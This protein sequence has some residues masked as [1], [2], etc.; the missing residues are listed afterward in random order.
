MC[1]ITGILN[2]RQTEPISRRAI[3][4]MIASLHHRGPDEAGIY[5]DD[6]IGLG[7]ARLSIIDL[8]GGAQPI[9]NEDESLWIVYNGEVFNYPELREG[10]VERG[11]S[12][13]TSSDTEVIL[14]LFEELG[15]A[16]LEQ[17][18]GQWA[19]AIWNAKTGELFLAR[20]RVGIRPLHYAKVGDRLIFGSEIKAIFAADPNMRRELDPAALDETFTFWTTLPGRTVFKGV[21][22]LP[23]GCYLTVS[24]GQITERQYW[25]ATFAPPD[26]Q[27]DWPVERLA[28]RVRQLL[29]DA[30]RLRLRA[31]VP[32]G[33]YLS[34]GLDSSALAMLVATGHNADVRTFGIRFEEAAFDEGDYQREMV[35]QLQT[36][37]QEILAANEEVG[38][39]LPEIVRHC[40]RP[41]LRTAPAPLFLLSRLV[42]E[43][44]FKVVLTGEGAD[45]LFGGYNIFREAKVRAFC[46][47]QPD[48]ELRAALI[49]RIYPYIFNNPRL[50][51]MTTSFFRQGMERTDDPLYSHLI[52]WTNTAKLKN[53][54]SPELRAAID[55]V[56]KDEGDAVDRVRGSLP[57]QFGQWEPLAKAQYLEMKLFLSNYLLSSQGD[58]M[59][60]ANSLEIRLPF[61]DYRLIDF[62]GQVPGRF[63]IAGLKEKALLKRAFRRDLPSRVVERA[64]HPYRAPIK[65]SLLDGRA[66]TMTEETL[67]E[68]RLKSAGLFDPAKVQRLLEKM[69]RAEQPSEVDNMSLVGMLSTQLVVEQFLE[70]PQPDYE[71]GRYSSEKLH[72]HDQRTIKHGE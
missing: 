65:Q 5:L 22:E 29:D 45:E 46:A 37:H 53:F 2:L 33:C 31:D 66:R 47:R 68:S 39:I 27:L 7:H 41:I 25:D 15:P 44:G 50:A 70:K 67:S 23:A 52:R 10:L 69:R 11:H 60:M 28:E 35:A 12:F 21:Q 8:A 42:H 3:E 36:A 48:S 4:S 1:G 34:G 51:K 30:T 49:A 20:D 6:R 32:V 14:H 19:L 16:C 9:A 54:F 40:E 71:L 58:R 64:K 17:L 61:L 26:E 59:A 43:C 55:D 24:Q 72:V 63:K 62:L 57:E 56:N 18:N 38:A 13:R